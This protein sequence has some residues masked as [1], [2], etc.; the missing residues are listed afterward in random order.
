MKL[1]SMSGLHGLQEDK[2]QTPD[3]VFYFF[4]SA[5]INKTTGSAI[6]NPILITSLKRLS[7]VIKSM[8]QLII[9]N[10]EEISYKLTG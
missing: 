7:N 2:F 9:D 8:E 10:F 3:T 1:T 4:H 6:I 5:E